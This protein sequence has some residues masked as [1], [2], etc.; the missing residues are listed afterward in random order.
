MKS[1]AAGEVRGVE[2]GL[3]VG[4]ADVREEGED[5]IEGRGDAEDDAPFDEC[6]LNQAL[7]AL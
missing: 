1:G 4:G 3:G 6:F 5:G 2:E 7:D